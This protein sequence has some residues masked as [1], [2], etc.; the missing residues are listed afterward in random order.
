VQGIIAG[1]PEALTTSLEG[2]EDEP[3][4]GA[5]DLRARGV[6][7]QDVVV[8]IAASGRTPYVAG[9]LEEANRLGA[10]TVAIVNV[11]DSALEKIAQI[12]LAALTGPEPLAGSTRLKAGTAQKLILNLLTTAT[13]VRL[14]KVYSNLMVDVQ[15]TNAKLRD[16]AV[17][18]VMAAAGAERAEAEAALNA[19]G[20]HAKTAIVMLHLG[21][22]PEEARKRLERAGGFVS[23]ALNAEPPA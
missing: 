18:I 7:A 6:T 16:R 20:N 13:M 17:R 14:G 5:E 8:G 11:R 23:R 19:A 4:T 10:V 1:G 15:A 9:A 21:L 2:A 3:A 12:T 22:S